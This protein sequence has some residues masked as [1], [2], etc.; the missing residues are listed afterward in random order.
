MSAAYSFL[1]LSAALTLLQWL[2]YIVSRLFSWGPLVFIN[3]Y[4]EGFPA[5]EPEPPIWAQRAKRAHSNMVETLPAF[6]VAVL[7]AEAVSPVAGF[8]ASCAALFFYSRLVYALVYILGIPFLRTPVYL[9]SWGAT[10]AI[11]AQLLT[12]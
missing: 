4:P 2:P 6:A 9:L 5:T 8:V 12:S 11:L 3:N 10:L 1:A 7:V